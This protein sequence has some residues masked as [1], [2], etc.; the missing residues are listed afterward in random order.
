MENSKW[1][2][3][4]N[5]QRDVILPFTR[6][7]LGPDGLYAWRHGECRLSHVCTHL[8]E[9]DE[10]WHSLPSARHVCDF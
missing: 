3:T 5:P 6:M 8:P 9:A 4:A 10:P 7:V 2:T 1:G